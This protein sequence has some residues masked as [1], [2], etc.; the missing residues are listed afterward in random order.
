[1]EEM[2]LTKSQFNEKL[3]AILAPTQGELIY[4]E[5][6]LALFSQLAGWDLG[7]CDL[8]RRAIGKKIPEEM[9][10]LKSRWLTDSQSNGGTVEQTNELWET[11]QAQAAYSFNKSHSY[12]Y[13]KITY[14][15]ARLKRYHPEAFYA[16]CLSAYT[17]TNDRVRF[18]GEARRKGIIFRAP[19]VNS[20]RAGY[21]I[22]PQTIYLGLERIVGE[23]A[24]PFILENRPFTSII[25]FRRKVP[26]K[27]CNVT[28]LRKLYYCGCF[29]GLGDASMLD[30]K[31]TA[32]NLNETI[33]DHPT[34]YPVPDVEYEVYGTWLSS[35]PLD[36]HPPE[37]ATGYE[38]L[39]A[40]GTACLSGVVCQ[41]TKKTTKA[42]GVMATVTIEGR[43][44][45]IALTVFPKHYSQ[46]KES[47][48]PGA[49]IDFIFKAETDGEEGMQY[50]FS[51]FGVLENIIVDASVRS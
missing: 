10:V 1:M 43:D 47:L 38:Q 17:Q 13:G 50:F 30:A 14:E 8:V 2:E 4:Q 49:V 40:E 15:T 19:H 7:E 21:S 18:S 28:K 41:V 6:C 33:G 29:D 23:K 34:D 5:Q 46:H 48:V 37:Y 24:M 25:D 36:N 26:A 51:G 31:L 11:I 22:G 44:G 3:E 45:A 42:G 12:A 27:V 20:G 32:K 16:G 9:A 39:G 35:H